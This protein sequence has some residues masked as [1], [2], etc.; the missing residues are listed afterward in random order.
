V[1]TSG[2]V[3]PRIQPDALP[4]IGRPIANTQVYILDAQLRR[5]P[6]GDIGELYIGGASL[7]RGY[8][9]RP[10]LTAERFIRH[11]FSDVP[12][13]QLYRTGDLARFLQ[14]GRIAF[15]GRVDTQ[16][17]I[18]GYRIEPDEIV[19]VLNS[20][21]AVEASVVTATATTESTGDK[22]L[23]AYIVPASGTQAS[24]TALQEHLRARLPDYM[25]PV[26]FVKLEA[27]PLTSNGKVDRAALPALN[28]ANIL[29]DAAP[30]TPRTPIE[31]RIAEIVATTLR[32]KQVGVDDNFFLLGGHS[33]LGTQVIARI[34][35]TLGVDLS[36]QA[37]FESPTVAELSRE[38]ERLILAKLD[39]MSDDEI[40]HLRL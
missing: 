23:V 12:G 22:I 8:L 33:L 37:L 7:S 5:V 25:I 4:S 38:V 14:D 40:Q 35:D 39:A 1:T 13:A 18:R 6:I 28:A 20:H 15:L 30:A 36:L 26:A 24:V 19:S 3:L 11:P 34:A 27:L 17:K 2:P 31:E 21:P 16:I 10:D 29:R 9:N 32:L